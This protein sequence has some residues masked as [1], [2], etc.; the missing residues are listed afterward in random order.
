MSDAMSKLLGVYRRILRALKARTYQ[1]DSSCVHVW[2][3]RN[4][5][6]QC[7]LCGVVD[8][9]TFWAEMN[10]GWDA[11]YGS[12]QQDTTRPLAKKK[13]SKIAKGAQ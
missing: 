1:A 10:R 7:K 3:T 12:A 2:R 9:K 13:S 5:I 4:N 6:R 8:G 11:K